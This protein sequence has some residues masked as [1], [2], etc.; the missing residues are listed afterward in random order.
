VGGVACI[1]GVMNANVGGLFKNRQPF[2]G[3]TSLEREKVKMC[4][5]SLKDS[6]RYTGVRGEERGL[7]R[8]ESN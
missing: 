4:V 3:N 6:E 8:A 5:V 7:L 2:F 1:R